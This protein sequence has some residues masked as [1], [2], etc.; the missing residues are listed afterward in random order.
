[1]ARPAD[2]SV[3]FYPSCDNVNP[4]LKISFFI[5]IFNHIFICP[6]NPES[7]RGTRIEKV[8]H[9]LQPEVFHPGMER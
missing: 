8:H 7:R 9:L 1:M 3:L 2:I 6:P 5:I 4:L